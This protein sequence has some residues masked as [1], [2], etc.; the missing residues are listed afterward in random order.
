MDR[1]KSYANVRRKLLEF[2]VGDM[3]LLKVSPNDAIHFGKKDKLSPRYI[4]P[5]E[6]LEKIGTV[7]YHVKLA[8]ELGNIHDTF[9]V[10][11]LRK[12]VA[13]E[14]LVIPHKEIKLDGK[15]NFVE[16]LI[17]VVDRKVKKLRRRQIPIVKIRWNLKR[18]PEFT[19]KMEGDAKRKY[20]HLFLDQCEIDEDACVI[21]DPEPLKCVA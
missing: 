4:G 20:P 5:F 21:D 6:L 18:G 12:C 15:L 17:E 10:S 13:D 19:W 14:S 1:Y 16:E 11:N 9:H 3:F 8:M 2:E 7:A